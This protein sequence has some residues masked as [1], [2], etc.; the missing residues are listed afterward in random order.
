MRARSP[1][2]SSRTPSQATTVVSSVNRPV[3]SDQNQDGLTALER[4]KR[5]H[6]QQQQS[7]AQ[8]YATAL[9]G[10]YDTSSSRE[11]AGAEAAAT[12]SGPDGFSVAAT[13]A[14]NQERR[15]AGLVEIC[16]QLEKQVA[17]EVSIRV[18]GTKAISDLI[19]KRIADA[20]RELESTYEDRVLKMHVAV[21]TLTNKLASLEDQLVVEREKNARLTEE[22]IAHHQEFNPAEGGVGSGPMQE[23]WSHVEHLKHTGKEALDRLV[24]RVTK[25]LERLD[26]R[27]DAEHF[28]RERQVADIQSALIDAVNRRKKE[29]KDTVDTLQQEI[30][31]LAQAVDAERREREVTEENIAETLEQLMSQLNNGR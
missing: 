12:G 19:D 30:A 24:E 31:A 10:P 28:A 27:V 9:S 23:L 5:R 22:L 20:V 7:H 21:D 6:Q 17:Q 25:E 29:D 14:V 8:N 13:V 1:G 11:G 26:E 16:S 15:L 4:L 2:L 18:K 3:H